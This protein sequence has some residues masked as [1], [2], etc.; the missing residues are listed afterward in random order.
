VL[1]DVLIPVQNVY[2]FFATYAEVDGW[3][4]SG[5]ELDY[6]RHAEKDAAPT[7]E[8]P[9]VGLSEAGRQYLESDEF[10]ENIQRIQPETVYCSTANRALETAE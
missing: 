3:K 5:T 9:N 4:H 2:N 8:D 10:V 6:M 7:V 1:K